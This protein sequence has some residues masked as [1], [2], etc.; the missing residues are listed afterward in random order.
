M[1]DDNELIRLREELKEI[2]ESTRRSRR[3]GAFGF[4]ILVLALVLCML[5]GFV[6]QVAATKNAEEALRQKD[7]ADQARVEAVRNLEEARRQE[8]IGHEQRVV[9]EKAMAEARAAVERCKGKK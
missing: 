4:V 5:Y 9:A 6:Q 2:Q 1:A 3:R 8:A 7:L